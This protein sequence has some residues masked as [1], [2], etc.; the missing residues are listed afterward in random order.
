MG[1]R[2][3]SKPKRWVIMPTLF[4]VGAYRVMVY[5]N[6][7]APPHVYAVSDRAQAKFELGS[8]PDAVRLVETFGI[9]KRELRALA[10]AIIDRHGECLA[11]W[12]SI[13]GKPRAT[14][15]RR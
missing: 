15:K 10:S 4:S 2:G 14:R 5:L 6:D 12:E 13:H 9:P 7:H 3:S 11:T 8:G 1:D